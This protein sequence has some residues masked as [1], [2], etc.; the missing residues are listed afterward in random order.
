[1]TMFY[2]FPEDAECWKLKDQYMFGPDYLVAP[3]LHAGETE[4]E[5]YLPAGTWEVFHT[6]EKL[7]GGRLIKAAAPIDRIP[8]FRK[9]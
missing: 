1:R 4:R 6:G 2:E 7:S 8:V 5:V 3:V 9:L